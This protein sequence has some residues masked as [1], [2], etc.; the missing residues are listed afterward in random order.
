MQMDTPRAPEK[1]TFERDYPGEPSQARRVRADLAEITGEC[2]AADDLILL[3]SELVANATTHSASGQDGGRF[4]VRVNL[5]P[6]DYAWAEVID[7]GGPWTPPAPGDEH[8]RGLT[9]VEAI[10]GD[11][12]W[13]IDG[14]TACRAIWFRL[15]W[16]QDQGQAS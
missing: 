8:G 7:Q 14:D 4:T 16:H 2:P 15:N 1:I 9:I 10:A 11:G 12:N 6:G 5:Y 3:A 13:G